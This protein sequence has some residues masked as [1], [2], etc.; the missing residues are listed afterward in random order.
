MRT[1]APHPA[2]SRHPPVPSQRAIGSANIIGYS[3]KAPPTPNA[4]AASTSGRT[5][6]MPPDPAEAPSPDDRSRPA[7]SNTQNATTVAQTANRSQLWN[8]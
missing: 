1:G 3:L 6:S 8:A 2:G 5:R 7:R 4:T